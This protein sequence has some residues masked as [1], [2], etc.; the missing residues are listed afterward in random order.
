MSSPA[1]RGFSL[2]ELM[3]GMALSLVVIAGALQLT[4]HSLGA[5]AR[6]Q[7]KLSLQ[8]DLRVATDIIARDLRRSAYWRG[9]GDG[10]ASSGRLPPHSSIVVSGTVSSAQVNYAYTND[11]AA[12]DADGSNKAAFRLNAESLQMREG[13]SAWQ[14]LTDPNRVRVTRF[15]ITPHVTEVSLGHLCEPV[16]TNTTPGCPRVRI[17][18]YDIALSARSA[19]NDSIAHDAHESVRIRNDDLSSATCP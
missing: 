9:A 19:G 2:V 8:R 16:C 13:D 17:R 15:E 3:V 1:H 11:A 14:E 18:S 6:L 5:N 12:N 7:S 4:A 10:T